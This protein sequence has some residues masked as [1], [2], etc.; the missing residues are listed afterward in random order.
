MIR[1]RIA[2]FERDRDTIREVRFAVFVEEQAVPPEL[3]M[4]DADDRCV[5]VLAFADESAV[6]TARI[7]FEH[8]GK[9]GRLAVVHPMRGRGIGTALMNRLHDLA[10]ERGLDGVWCHAQ[11]A[12]EP[13]Y[14]KLG[15]A[16]SG[17]P[18]QEAGIEH[19]RMEKFLR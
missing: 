2:D 16:A 4:D 9:V 5:H 6:G 17:P 15:Y 19:V 10:R 8:A 14:T 12:A 1:I 13:F 3:E 18:L 7:D 11:I